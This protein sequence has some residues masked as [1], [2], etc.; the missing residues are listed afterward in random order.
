MKMSC[1]P[2]F[3]LLLAVFLA[4]AAPRARAQEEG[5]F[6]YFYDNLKPYGE[7]IQ[8]ADYGLCWRPSDVDEDWAPYTDGYWAYTDAGWTW[9]SYEDFGDIVYHYGRWVRVEDEGWCWVPDSDWG[10]A[11]VSWRNNDEYVGWAP[12]PPEARFEPEVGFSVW[13]DDTYDIGPNYYRFC[14]VQDF[15]APVIRAVCFPRTRNLACFRETVNITNISF[16]SGHAFCGGPRYDFYS[17]RVLRPI[18][19]LRLV[20]ETN[21]VNINVNVGGAGGRHRGFSSIQRGN[22]LLMPAPHIRAVADRRTVVANVQPARVVAADRVTRG[23]TGIRPQERD[24]LRLANKQQTRNATPQ[25][26]HAKPVAPT[27]LKPLPTKVVTEGPG[28]AG[29]GRG[30]QGKQWGTGAPGTT[31]PSVTTGQGSRPGGRGDRDD[32][33]NVSGMAGSRGLNKGNP[34]T[35]AK[36]GDTVGRPPVTAGQGAKPGVVTPGKPGTV[37]RPDVDDDDNVRPRN[38]QN[39]GVI[40]KGKTTAPN[41]GVVPWNR[42]NNAPATR[43]PPATTGTTNPKPVKRFDDDDDVRNSPTR[44]NVITPVQPTQP[45]QRVQP[46]QPIPRVQPTQPIQRIQPTQPVDVPRSPVAPNTGGF[47]RGA[48]NSPNRVE[49][50]EV[51]RA[52]KPD[53]DQIQRQQAAAKQQQASLAAQQQQAAARQQQAIQ[54]QQNAAAERNRA[55]AAEASRERAQAQAAQRQSAAAA[56]AARERAIQSQPRPQALPPRPAP[57]QPQAVPPR[58]TSSDSGKDKD[59][60]KDDKKRR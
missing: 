57:V 10:P 15:G 17:T 18:P 21:I 5:S 52:P 2:V 51:N 12:L 7:W 31:R 58:P 13:V 22:A 9:V 11:W 46:T 50:P 44:P 41:T 48:S 32:D 28:V 47:K 40:G 45:I 25:T 36:P 23:W 37:T 43:V 55:A 20:R 27:E 19:T 49:T 6:D 34:P 54:A 14:R 1:P 59:K 53:Y 26:A 56:A 39:P 60:D 8:V 16:Y 29:T 33:D 24:E 42:E 35:T 38:P 30:S 4:F 3:L